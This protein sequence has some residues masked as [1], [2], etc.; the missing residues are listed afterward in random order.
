MSLLNEARALA[1]VLTAL[2]HS[3]HREP[4]LGLDLPLTQAKVIAA[5]EELDLEITHGR[6]LSSVT[7]VLRGGRP[8]PAVL[9]RGDMDALPVHEDSGVSYASVI[10]GRMHACGHDLHTTG[11]VGAAHLLAARREQL[12]GDVVFMFQPGEEGQGGA[13]IMIDEGVLDAAG[14][15]VV[16]AYALHVVSR[17]APTGFA[18]TR[19]GPVLAASDTVHVTV[20]GV[21]G[22]GSS[23]HAAADPVPALCT[24]VTALQTLVTREID[25]FDPAVVTVG[26]LEAGTAP[27]VIPESGRFSATVRTFSDASRAA[28]RMA[29]ERTV[30]GIAAAHRVSVDIDYVHQYPPTINHDGE[31]AFAI[32]AARDVLGEDRVFVAPT[33]LAGS[34]DF[35]FVLREVP[36]A[37][38]GLGACPAGTDPTTAPMNHSPQAVYDDAALPH[39]AALLAGL[40]LRRLARAASARSDSSSSSPSPSV[41]SDSSAGSPVSP[42]SQE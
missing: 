11:L 14:E 20:R 22:H 15:R 12:A 2:R 39:A 9:L 36:G 3:L 19:P 1:P 7:A 42:S 5:L 40:A 4:E 41:T 32:E 8:G 28:V 17:G 35:S 33:P 6:A 10:D 13:K 18:A 38:L 24:M 34:E 29:F 16:A 27:N 31:T 26:R 37:F 30:H 23:P 25:I 21:G